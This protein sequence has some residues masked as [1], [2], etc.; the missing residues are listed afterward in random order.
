[1]LMQKSINVKM[2]DA[3]GQCA[4]SKSVSHTDVVFILSLF[5]AFYLSHAS[6]LATAHNCGKS[7]RTV[8]QY[9]IVAFI[10]RMWVNGL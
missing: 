10:V 5:F 9:F 2:I 7:S 4:T 1:M 3:H 8:F 6:D